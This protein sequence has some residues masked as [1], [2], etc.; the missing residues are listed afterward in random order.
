MSA[1]TPYDPP[2]TEV[3]DSPRSRGRFSRLEQVLLVLLVVNA[4]LGLGFIG[5]A[6]LKAPSVSA[7]ATLAGLALP[8]LGFVAAGLMFKAQAVGLWLGVAFY[9]P[10]IIG[11]FSRNGSF[12]AQSGLNLN[13]SFS[14]GQGVVVVNLLAI[15]LALL[16]IRAALLRRAHAPS[17]ESAA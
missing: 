10:Q 15:A 11:Y 16:H 9:L 14:Q 7:L 17:L 12:H 13:V 4:T 8:V 1:P 5:W 3:S 2:G 6:V